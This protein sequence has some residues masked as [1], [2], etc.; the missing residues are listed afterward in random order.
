MIE[1]MHSIGLN[2][3]RHTVKC[4][5]DGWYWSYYKGIKK[6]VPITT[7]YHGYKFEYI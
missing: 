4:Y 5:A 6:K 1:Y 3:D 2:I 7:T